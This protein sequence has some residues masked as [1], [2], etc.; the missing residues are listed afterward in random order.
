MLVGTGVRCVGT[1]GA[2]A[3][4]RRSPGG[5]GITGRRWPSRPVRCRRVDHGVVQRGERVHRIGTVES[6]PPPRRTGDRTLGR[7]RWSLQHTPRSA[8]AP[9]WTATSACPVRRRGRARPL[10]AWSPADQGAILS[11][12]GTGRAGGIVYRA[13]R[14]NSAAYAGWRRLCIGAEL[15]RG[16]RPLLLEPGARPAGTRSCSGLAPATPG[17]GAQP[18]DRG[19]HGDG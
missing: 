9:P 16:W 5:T 17:G 10:G 15:C 4:R 12:G 2:G 11:T 7:T 6:L 18:T 13:T 8:P 19:R 3:Y 1:S 14:R